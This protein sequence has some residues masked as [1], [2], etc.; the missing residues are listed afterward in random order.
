MTDSNSNHR[1][2]VDTG[3]QVS[4]IPA[5]FLD[6]RSGTATQHLEAANGT[7]IATYGARNVP[8]RFGKKVYSSKRMFDALF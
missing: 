5:T 7:A 8:L 1:F 4:G 2:L 6:R 3:A